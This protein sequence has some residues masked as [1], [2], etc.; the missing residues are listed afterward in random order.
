MPLIILDTHGGLNISLEKLGKKDKDT[1]KYVNLYKYIFK[2]NRIVLYI[3][4]EQS[5]RVKIQ[6]VD[7]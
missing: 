6:K 7:R 1:K 2:S 3:K 5:P 4:E